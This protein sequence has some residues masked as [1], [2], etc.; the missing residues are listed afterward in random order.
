MSKREKKISDQGIEL[1]ASADLSAVIDTTDKSTVEK[2]P[3]SLITDT[4]NAVKDLFYTSETDAKILPFVGS[5]ADS[6][7]K[8]NLLIQ[9]KNESNTK[10][11]TNYNAHKI[12][13]EYSFFVI[14]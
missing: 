11:F 2:K 10:H 3:N 4:E 1:S 6:V 5:Q 9:T 7:T 14:L 12:K 13:F 8:E